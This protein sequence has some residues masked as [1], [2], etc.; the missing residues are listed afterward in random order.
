MSESLGATGLPAIVG[1]SGLYHDSAAAAVVGGEVIAAVQEERFTRRKHDPNLPER[2]LAWCLEQIGGRERL[3]AIAF[4]EDPALS[5]DRVLRNAVEMA[6][7]SAAS[8]PA[9]ARSQLGQ[10]LLIGDALRR[11]LPAERSGN[12]FVVDHHVSH[13]ASAF[14]PSPFAEAAVVVADGIGEW[15]STT[16]AHGKGSLIETLS[17]IRYPHSLGLFYSAFTYHCGLKVNSGEYKLMGLAP[18]GQP[19]YVDRIMDRMI[20]LREDGSYR[21]NTEFFGW[22]TSD[23]ATTAAF[24]A[25]MGCPRRDPESM[26]TIEYM[27]IAASA[28]AVI[29]EAMLRIVRTALARTGSGNLCLAGGVALN[30]VTNG[31]LIKRLPELKRIWIQPA[32]GDAG[33][34]LGAALHVAH[35]A[36]GQARHA[37]VGQRDGQKGSLLGP[38]YGEAAVAAA[39]DAAGLVAHHFDSTEACVARTAEALAAGLIIGRFEGAMEFG[40]RALGNRSILADPRRLDGQAY[41][42][43][44]VKFRES[45]RPFAP[46]VLADHSSTYFD[47]DDES[48]YM[49]LVA[50]VREAFRRPVDWGDFREGS[51]DMFKVLG[52]PRSTLPSITHVD[53]SARI[54]TVDAER[55]PP[56]H[57][58]LSRFHALTGCPILINTSFNVRGEPIVCDPE[59][60]VRCFLNTGIDVLAFGNH[61]VFKSEQS[62][63]I[64]LMEGKMEFAP[65]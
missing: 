7:G 25:V 52:Q 23:R 20:D 18:Y 17:E 6:P 44:R 5:M 53:Y 62:E 56:F 47:L 59:D 12:V 41:I 54:Q 4:Y 34:A 57:A 31:K 29:D 37:G 2:A 1:V 10:K 21:L 58:L 61:L 65:D 15:A 24:E 46:V 45:W 30:C 42:N 32:A 48:P 3:E 39:I 19:R 8:W 50:D 36:Y 27:D 14:Y 26:L 55:N 49:L 51:A 33:G 40:P 43:L 13:A 38:S 35:T 60:A 22:L 64:R 28:Q 11:Y 16:V 9:A 63:A